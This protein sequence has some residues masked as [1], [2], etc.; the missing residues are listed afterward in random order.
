MLDDDSS[1]VFMQDE[2]KTQNS[3]DHELIQRKEIHDHELIDLLP[4]F[5]SHRNDMKEGEEHKL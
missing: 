5:E 2:V 4:R 3:R 1:I